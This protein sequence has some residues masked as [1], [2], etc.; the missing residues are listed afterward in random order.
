MTP[1]RAVQYLRTSSRCSV[2]D[3]TPAKC[4]EVADVIEGCLF[5]EQE[6]LGIAQRALER[7][8]AATAT[9]DVTAAPIHALNGGCELKVTQAVA[10]ERERCARMAERIGFNTFAAAIRASPEVTK[11]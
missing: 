2:T 8:D 4:G 1:E 5:R 11:P 6:A 3:I 9:V 10:A 7:L